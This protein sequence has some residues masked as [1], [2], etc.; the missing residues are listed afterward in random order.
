MPEIYEYNG[1][2]V[3]D[4]NCREIFQFINAR[5]I[6]ALMFHDQMADTYDFLG[7]NGFKR[8]HEYQYFAESAEH[9]G[10]KRYFIN[11]HNKLLESAKIPTKKVIPEDWTKYDRF[12]VTAQI[13]KQ[14]IEKSFEMYENWES[15]TKE[16]YEYCA[17][18]LFD[19]GRIADFEKVKELI[20]DVDM[21]LKCLDRLLIELKSVDFNNVYMETIQS[22]LHERYDKK[23]KEININIC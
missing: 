21:E 14:H 15:D 19:L 23:T 20:C 9:R 16:I 7:L 10:L 6:A 18:C 2:Q 5:Q 1:K 4:M 3:K 11:H 17:K 22:E 12:D 13:R 8:L